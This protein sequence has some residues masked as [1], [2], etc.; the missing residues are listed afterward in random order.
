MSDT[1]YQNTVPQWYVA[2]TYSGYENKVRANLEK[3]IENRSL[4]HL[5]TDIKIPTEVS[6]ERDKDG[7]E[8]EVESKLLP[9]YV[10]VKMIMTDESWHAVRT[11]RG[12]TGFVGPA[13]RPVPLSEEEVALMGVEVRVLTLGYVVGDSVKITKGALNGFIG[14]VKEISE[15]KKK[16]KVL[17]SMF[18]RETPVELDSDSVVVLD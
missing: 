5:I 2:Q 11:V 1:S 17:A 18:G 9:A 12:V 10:L 6:V 3:V 8:V 13:S 16:I 15:D 4:E 7:K 14:V